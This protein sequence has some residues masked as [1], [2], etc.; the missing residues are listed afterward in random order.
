ML[1]IAVFSAENLT[2]IIR[3]FPKL[4]D[5]IFHSCCAII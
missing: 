3:Q 4:C 5:K 2:I 1:K